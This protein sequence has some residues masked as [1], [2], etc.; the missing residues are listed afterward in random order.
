[1]QEVLDAIHGW[2]DGN[3]MVLNSKKTKDMWICFK[4]SMPG[5]TIGNGETEKVNSFKLLG[6]WVQNNLK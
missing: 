1:M 6:A 4:D 2:A 5:T 3:K